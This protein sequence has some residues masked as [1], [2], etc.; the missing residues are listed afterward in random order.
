MGGCC[1]DGVGSVEMGKAPRL[2]YAE[3]DARRLIDAALQATSGTTFISST[4]QIFIVDRL[5]TAQAL[6]ATSTSNAGR[7]ALTHVT[8][9]RSFVE[10]V[11]APRLRALLEMALRA[12]DGRPNY[13]LS[14]VELPPPGVILP[15]DIEPPPPDTGLPPPRKLTEDQITANWR[16]L[17]VGVAL[18]FVIYK[19]TTRNAPPSVYRPAHIMVVDPELPYRSKEQIAADYERVRADVFGRMN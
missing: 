11:E 19:W 4:M 8:R 12:L 13:G 7:Q 18:F 5:R 14:G 1:G 15:P 6:L 10:A 2:N 17:A 9:A 3:R 16:N